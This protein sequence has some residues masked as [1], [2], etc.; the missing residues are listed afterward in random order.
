MRSPNKVFALYMTTR[1]I[2]RKIYDWVNP[3]VTFEEW[4]EREQERKRTDADY[5]E[6][7][8]HIKTERELRKAERALAKATQKYADLRE[9]ARTAKIRRRQL[10]DEYGVFQGDDDNP[11]DWREPERVDAYIAAQEGDYEVV[12]HNEYGGKRIRKRKMTIR[13]HKK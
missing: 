10:A 12:R 6:M 4:R 3:P 7:L 13:R 5:D 1:K 2:M 11:V 8:V 9:K